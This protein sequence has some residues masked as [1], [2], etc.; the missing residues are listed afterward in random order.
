[1]YDA[2]Y[3]VLD[4]QTD[5]INNSIYDISFSILDYKHAG[6]SLTNITNGGLLLDSLVNYSPLPQILKDNSFNVI[7]FKN[8][9]YSLYSIYYDLKFTSADLKNAGYTFIQMKNIGLSLTE[10]KNAGFTATDLLNS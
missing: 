5:L 9:D 1:M 7:D 6:Y 8:I 4:I 2:N 10:L 3:S